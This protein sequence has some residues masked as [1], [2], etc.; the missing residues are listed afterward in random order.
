MNTKEKKELRKKR[1][2]ILIT[3]AKLKSTESHTVDVLSKIENKINNQTD[4]NFVEIIKYIENQ[5]SD[6][7]G[8][9]FIELNMVLNKLIKNAKNVK[10]MLK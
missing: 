1:L 10:E 4:F 3:I 2:L 6:K 5:R 9:R 8:G 7:M